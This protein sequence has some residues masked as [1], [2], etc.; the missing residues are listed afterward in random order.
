MWNVKKFPSAARLA[1][2]RKRNAHRF[3]IVE[4]AINNGWAV[5][6]KPLRKVY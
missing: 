6:F 1:E 3:Q 4:I 5:E 2:W